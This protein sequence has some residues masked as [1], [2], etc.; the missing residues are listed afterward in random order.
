M[1]TTETQSSQRS[2]EK[3]RRLG[4]ARLPPS[5]TQIILC[6]EVQLFSKPRFEMTNNGYDETLTFL[7]FHAWFETLFFLIDG[8]LQLASLVR[9][10][11]GELWRRGIGIRTCL[12]F[13]DGPAMITPAKFNYAFPK[14]TDGEAL[15]FTMLIMPHDP[16]PIDDP[17]PT[18][19]ANVS[20]LQLGI[21]FDLL[22]YLLWPQ[23]KCRA[24][25][26][27]RREDEQREQRIAGFECHY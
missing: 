15:H 26:D 20:G 9:R 4:K 5:R 6:E 23:P 13:R 14:P 12:L 10:Q 25:G 22:D 1:R 24:A 16:R 3:T 19:I 17:V 27:K 2:R 8:T 7:G 18:P 21:R 11:H